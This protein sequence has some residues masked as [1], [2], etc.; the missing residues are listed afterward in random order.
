MDRVKG[1]LYAAVSSATFGFAPFFT[2][3]LLGCGYSSFE[4]LSYRWGIASLGLILVSIGLKCDFRL[5]KKEVIVVVGLSLLR[6]LTSFSLVL[7]YQYI[8]TGVASTIHF[9]YPL[10]VAVTMMLFFKEKKSLRVITAVGISI[11]G[12]VLLSGETMEGKGHHIFGIMMACLSVFSY[13]GYIIGVRKSRAVRI[14]SNVLTCYVMSIGAIIFMI[15]ASLSG[16]L[17]LETHG[18][19]WLYI[20]GLA[21]PAT[22]ISNITL[23]KAIKYI[24]P[25]LT[26]VFGALEPLTAVVVGV[27]F[28]HEL[29]TVSGALGILFILFA[30][31]LVLFKKEVQP[32]AKAASTPAGH[33]AEK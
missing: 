3:L 4:V 18:R 15:C 16:G 5:N 28:F 29:F 2:L 8:A 22:A 20:L 19:E 10:A 30:V 11:I 6:A 17:R 9:M 31:S 32:P 25:T 7:A 26:S 21:L 27:F 23:I 13:S 14:H 33:I 12:A 24:G 1:I